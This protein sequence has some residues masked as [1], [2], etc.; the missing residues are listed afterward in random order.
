VQPTEL[1]YIN[2]VQTVNSS[3]IHDLQWEYDQ[4]VEIFNPNPYQVD[5]ANYSF[6]VGSNVWTIANNN[7]YRTIIPA[8]GFG[9]YWFDGDTQDDTNH[10]PYLLPISNATIILKGPD[11]AVV[12]SYAYTSIS[13]NTSWGRSSDGAPSSIVFNVPT[14]RVSN[15]STFI[16]PDMVV[17]N[18][19]MP[20]NQTDTLDNAGQLEDWFEFY[21]PLNHPAN[22]GGYYVTDDPDNPQKWRIPVDFVDSVTIDTHSWMLFW[23]DDDASQGV[24]HAAF[25]F[26][27]NGEYCGL[28]GSDGFT[29]VDEIKWNHINPDTSYGRVT[30]GAAQWVEFWNTTPEYSNG[31]GSISVAEIENVS[32]HVYPNPS[33]DRFFFSEISNVTLYDIAGN[34]LN[35]YQR[36]QSVDASSWTSGLYLLRDDKGNTYRVIKN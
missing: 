22:L 12:D 20:A 26:S 10:S 1:L 36:V 16:A 30:D 23:A 29:L 7:P 21:N 17:I 11:G 15:S 33:H 24:R 35:C 8:N 14:P 27:N 5:L 18:E 2:E 28:Y 25:K 4:W 6:S 13:A 32:M 31:Q 3:T 9:I 19:V 34:K